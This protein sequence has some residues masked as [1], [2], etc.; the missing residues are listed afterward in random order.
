M[1][2]KI[3][4]VVILVMS[5]MLLMTSWLVAGQWTFHKAA[6]K[7]NI[8]VLQKYLAKKPGIVNKIGEKGASALHWAARKN[9][10]EAVKLLLKNGADVN[11]KGKN[12]K[13]TPLHYAILGANTDI[14]KMIVDKGSDIN[15]RDK[16]GENA[17]Y[18]SAAVG[19]I[20]LV[21]Y[22]MKK[23]LKLKGETSKIHTNPLTYATERGHLETAKWLVKQGV[24]PRVQD[25]NKFNLLHRA[26]WDGKPD[27]IVWLLEQGLDVNAKTTFGRTPLHN[28]AMTGNNDGV[29]VLL[30]KGA[31]VDYTSK[32]GWNALYLA[33]K[34]GYADTVAILLKAG[35][36]ASYTQ[37]KGG[38]S[39][40]H[41]AA[42]Q[43]Y[44]KITKMLVSKGANP[45]VRDT[46]GKT[47]LYYAA[48][49]GHKKAA[50]LLLAS[51]A[52]KKDIGK[53]NF[54]QAKLL[55]KKLNE[56]DALV[57]Y[58]GH[59]GWAVKTRNHFLVFDYYK[60]KNR[61]DTPCLS[62]GSI[63]CQEINGVNAV[64]FAS[65]AHGDHYM[66]EIFDWKKSSPN[67]KYVMGFHPKEKKDYVYIPPRK[68]KK[69]GDMEITTIKSNDSGVGFFVKVDGVA[70]FH[71]GDHANRKRDFSGP[72]TAEIDF[73]AK[74]NMKP[75]LLFTPVSGCGFGDQVAVKKGAYY[76][77]KKLSP[78]VWFP[79][80][81]GGGEERY[82]EFAK[83]AHKKG[84]KTPLFC[85]E[86]SGDRFFFRK[87]ANKFAGVFTPTS[88][89]SFD[90][91]GKMKKKKAASCKAK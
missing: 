46:A 87:D 34:R 37:K 32:E 36:N 89:K 5:A 54:S 71:P 42:N 60:G 59:S 48:K 74:N 84:F 77:V 9:Q 23:G 11:L 52:D 14:I 65:H 55:A 91:N 51:G 25:K 68:T 7:G 90:G 56:G 27:M 22:F 13:C 35:A 29:M 4:K 16:D 53:K 39:L 19:R 76:A 10:V 88:L 81:A 20:D 2:G 12:D 38:K 57:W 49:Y 3:F 69:I 26:A 21:K 73:L 28:A 17:L 64:V 8:E 80:H 30:K 85:A 62:N 18:Y 58:T 82:R 44:G 15:S 24:D 6:A 86:N 33:V 31:D 1:H 41:L 45:N 43:G 66:S 78:A 63:D 67:I 40:L 75:D 61:P 79:M 47:P 83:E 70:I 50:K 72:Y